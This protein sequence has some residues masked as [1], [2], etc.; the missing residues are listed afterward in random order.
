MPLLPPSAY[1][2]GMPIVDDDLPR[3]TVVVGE[4]LR[5]WLESDGV[6]VYPRLPSRPAWPAVRPVRIGGVMR[7]VRAKLDEAIMDFDVW[8]TGDGSAETLANKTRSY[9][10]EMTGVM[11]RD[12]VVTRTFDSAG[13]AP[14]P[15]DDPALERFGFTVGLLF[16]PA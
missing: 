12:I 16:H 5:D 3:I 6:H 14:R 1:T 15:E 13:P 10:L 2:M 8:T 4:Y 9:M 11:H 7:N